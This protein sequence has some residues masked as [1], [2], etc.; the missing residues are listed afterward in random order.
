MCN[1]GAE[2]TTDHKAQKGLMMQHGE[3]QDPDSVSVCN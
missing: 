3:Q 1:A 2:G